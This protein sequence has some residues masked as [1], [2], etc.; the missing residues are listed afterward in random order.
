MC[1]LLAQLP[2]SSPYIPSAYVR[3]CVCPVPAGVYLAGGRRRAECG[4]QCAHTALPLP[5]LVC[6]GVWGGATYVRVRV[7][8]VWGREGGGMPWLT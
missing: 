5:L 1:V 2:I 7:K 8:D 3:A 4:L 6:P